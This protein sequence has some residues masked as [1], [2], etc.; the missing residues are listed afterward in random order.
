MDLESFDFSSR[1]NSTK[2]KRMLSC[3]RIKLLRNRIFLLAFEISRKH[4]QRDA[5]RKRAT[6]CR[7]VSVCLSVCLSP[8]SPTHSRILII[9]SLRYGG[10]QGTFQRYL[11]LKGCQ[12]LAQN[13]SIKQS[14][15]SDSK[16]PS[17]S[18]VI[19]HNVSEIMLLLSYSYTRSF[20]NNSKDYYVSKTFYQH[21]HHTHW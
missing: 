15:S 18:H 5:I 4:L 21:N 2:S 12:F 1:S 13:V 9:I 6:N 3:P 20:H 8:V 11:K 14:R 10:Q 19:G 17:N 16:Y 7:P